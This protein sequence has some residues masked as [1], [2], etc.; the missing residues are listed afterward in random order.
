VAAWQQPRIAKKTSSMHY[1]AIGTLS[2]RC[3]T[4][5]PSPSAVDEI[6]DPEL[7]L[8][9][10][11]GAGAAVA[12]AAAAAAGVVAAAAVTHQLV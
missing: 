6:P 3:C 5:V 2:L 10:E 9:L 1:R 11:A 7:V 12:A 4:T 8:V